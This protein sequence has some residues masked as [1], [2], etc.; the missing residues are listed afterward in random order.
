MYC[1]AGRRVRN[2]I[3]RPY[4]PAPTDPY[5]TGPGYAERHRETTTLLPSGILR[6]DLGGPVDG[7]V[8]KR[9]PNPKPRPTPPPLPAVP[10][11]LPPEPRKEREVPDDPENRARMEAILNR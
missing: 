9:K 7:S 10:P 8:A 1:L 11:A 4:A 2:A 6:I 5:V 3:L